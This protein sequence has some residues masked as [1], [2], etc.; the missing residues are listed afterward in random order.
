M[1]FIL[2]ALKKHGLT[3]IEQTYEKLKA[4]PPNTIQNR[5]AYFNALLGV[6]NGE[7]G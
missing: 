2:S 1:T 4:A 7:S 5:G 3:K 6:M